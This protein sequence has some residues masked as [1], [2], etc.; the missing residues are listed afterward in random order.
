MA[1]KPPKVVLDEGAVA[2]AVGALES[3]ILE[4]NPQRTRLAVVGI[5]TGGV[6]LARRIHKTL[7]R[8]SRVD[9]PFGMLDITLYRDDLDAGRHKPV[10]K[11]TQIGFNVADRDVILVDDVLFTGRTVRA[12]LDEIVDFGR[13]RS[14]QLAVLIDRGHRELPIQPDF[15][16]VDV[17]T[18]REDRIEVRFHEADG[19]DEVLLIPFSSGAKS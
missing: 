5:H 19:R 15:K 18:D 1:A 8:A 4:R 16:G 3:G 9:I 13:P 2:R 14:I 12:A 17:A 11:S 10:V 6:H 7:E